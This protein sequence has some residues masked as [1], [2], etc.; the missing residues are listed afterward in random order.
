MKYVKLCVSAVSGI[1]LKIK[2]LGDLAHTFI[3]SE[4]GMNHVLRLFLLLLND[5]FKF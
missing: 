1:F 2:V 4:M 3:L 5:T